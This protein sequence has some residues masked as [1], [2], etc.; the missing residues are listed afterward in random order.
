MIRVFVTILILLIF[1]SFAFAER[2]YKF[3][4]LDTTSPEISKQISIEMSKSING[5]YQISHQIDILHD[6]EKIERY[7]S[8]FSDD[9]IQKFM[10][11]HR[12]DYLMY[13][14]KERESQVS[15]TVW[16]QNSISENVYLEY[17]SSMDKY[18]SDIAASAF[19]SIIEVLSNQFSQNKVF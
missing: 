16:D 10:N 19:L 3:C 14:R 6:C 15:F 17:L 11:E 5:Y 7:I 12:I 18:F 9:C 8:D 13:I 1:Y 2:M 4:L